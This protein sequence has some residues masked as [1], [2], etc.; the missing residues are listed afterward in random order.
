MFGDAFDPSHGVEKTPEFQK[1]K[2][3]LGCFRRGRGGYL[4]EARVRLCRSRILQV[5]SHYAVFV[6]IY[7]IGAFWQRSN[8]NILAIANRLI[9][10]VLEFVDIYVLLGCV[11]LM[12]F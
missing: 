6:E 9:D 7:K 3:T 11:M 1:S 12:N 8:L 10:V 2:R 5:H 4:S